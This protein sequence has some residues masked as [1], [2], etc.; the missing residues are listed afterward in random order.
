[1]ICGL[2]DVNALETAPP[3][4][5]VA[6]YEN[7]S[8]LEHSCIANTRYSFRVDVRGRPRI[9]VYAVTSIKKYVLTF[10]SHKK[11]IRLFYEKFII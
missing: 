7:A 9:T 3:E 1:M 11:I 10:I 8:L 2:I 4:G 6:I 5:S